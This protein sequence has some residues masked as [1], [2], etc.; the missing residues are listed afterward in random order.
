MNFEKEGR[1]LKWVEENFKQF[2]A[3]DKKQQAIILEQLIFERVQKLDLQTDKAQKVAGML[4]DLEIMEV[5]EIIEM[6]KDEDNLKSYVDEALEVL[7]ETENV[8]EK[9]KR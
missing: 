9:Q 4:S 2:Q 5:E 7:K 8:D 6:L 1:D 3:L